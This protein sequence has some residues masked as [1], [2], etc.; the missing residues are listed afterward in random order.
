MKKYGAI[1]IGVVVLSVLVFSV[2]TSAV[3]DASE[4]ATFYSMAWTDTSIFSRTTGPGRM[5]MAPLGAGVDEAVYFLPQD[6]DSTT[7]IILLTNT[8]NNTVQVSGTAWLWDGS[9]HSSGLFPLGAHEM[10]TLHSNDAYGYNG[11]GWE[12]SGA[13]SACLT[14]PPGV[15][16]DGFIAWNGNQTYHPD[17]AC[18]R[19]PLQFTRI[20]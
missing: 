10:I 11:I 7:T 14:L 5:D 15:V 12:L 9:L 20:Q 1:L 3:G 6:T 4:G 2:G 17:L 13:A 8:T 19:R 16:L 18:H